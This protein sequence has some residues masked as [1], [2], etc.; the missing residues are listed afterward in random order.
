MGTYGQGCCGCGG[1]IGRVVGCPCA[2]WWWSSCDVHYLYKGRGV[3][4]VVVVVDDVV[5]VVLVLLELVVVEL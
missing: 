1:S 5:L 4:V 3:E 2:A